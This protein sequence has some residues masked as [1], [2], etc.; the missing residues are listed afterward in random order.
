M[1]RQTLAI[2]LGLRETT[3]IAIWTL[4]HIAPVGPIFALK[5]GL[6]GK[7]DGIRHISGLQLFEKDRPVHLYRAFG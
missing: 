4:G 3:A 1:H 2:K 7:P 5:P 6:D